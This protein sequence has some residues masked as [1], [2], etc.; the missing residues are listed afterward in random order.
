MKKFF[1][2][3]HLIFVLILFSFIPLAISQ[4]QPVPVEKST[5]KI[6]YQGKTYYVH[7]VKQG[8]TLYSICKTYNVT[9][10]II[11]S[12]NSGV[13]LNPLS[14]GQILKIP[15][16]SETSPVI[17]NP[18]AETIQDENFYY[19]T[20]K[21]QENTYFLHQKYNV[22]LELIYKYN[23]GAENGIQTGQVIRIPKKSMQ[24]AAPQSEIVQQETIRQYRVKQGD[25]L[26]R[27]AENF[28]LTIGNLIDT[29]RELRWGF[30]PGQIIII[31]SVDNLQTA[32]RSINDTMIHVLPLTTLSSYQCDSIASLKRMHPTLKVAVLL[33]FY[34]DESFSVESIADSDSI[35]DDGTRNEHKMFKGIAAVE[36]YE[37]LLLAVD[38]L[39][40]L[41]SGISLFVYDTEADPNKV[42]TILKE[43]E[44]IEPDLIFG[45]MT[46]EN[47]RLVSKFAFEH[48]IPVIP[49]LTNEDSVLDYNP[50]LIQTIPSHDEELQFYA[51]YI[52]QFNNKNI[53]LIT[54]PDIQQIQENTRFKEL[55]SSQAAK[56]Y[57]VDSLVF[58]EISIDDA[59]KKN[60]SRS[61]KKDKEN[62]VVILSTYEPDVINVL[63][64]LHF[65]LRDYKIEV[66]GLPQWQRFDNV[67]I[68]VL[69]ELQVSLYT[70]F[71]ID[72]SSPRVKS[73]VETCRSKLKYEPF[74]TTAKG[75]GI[76]YAFM[77]YD[78]GI[79]FLEALNTYQ[80]N[81][82]D[83]IEN[84]KEKL[85]LSEYDYTRNNPQGN[86][87]NKHINIIKF[88][89]EY[90][91]ELVN[92]K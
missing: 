87:V 19:H 86:Y 15:V 71:Y 37:G 76:N 60:I 5:E 89:K 46:L 57:G 83:C 36:F 7:M 34:A 84:K 63:S 92:F 64:H 12:S 48:K 51:R 49:P 31:P 45:P 88:N 6:L 82:C 4:F 67:R 91:V 66:F 52:A 22:P 56:Y 42:K 79:Y 50:L 41:N 75:S 2:K 81:L 9:E 24:E 68:E 14:V 65:L 38:T 54:K 35:S 20:V 39:K 1:K 69:H 17:E 33:P 40:K 73:F 53:L 61:L 13:K 29:N 28:G 16:T 21:P 8:Q 43:L 47:T 32:S 58:S 27:V 90:E 3:R 10:P 26:Y 23:P 77:G 44:I 80:K 74:K 62:L 11:A 85:L 70:P 72:Y 55:L 18:K 78:L 25:S 59:V 30:K